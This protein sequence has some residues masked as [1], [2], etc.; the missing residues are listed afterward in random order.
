MRECC[1]VSWW[2]YTAI[3]A[4]QAHQKIVPGCRELTRYAR[5]RKTPRARPQLYPFDVIVRGTASQVN[6]AGTCAR[7]FPSRSRK[8]PSRVPFNSFPFFPFSMWN[9]NV[10]FSV[11]MDVPLLT[12]ASW[13]FAITCATKLPCPSLIQ[14]PMN[15]LSRNV[16]LAKETPVAYIEGATSMTLPPGK[17]LMRLCRTAVVPGVLRVP[18][19][20]P[21]KL[22]EE[23]SSAWLVPG[24]ETRNASTPST[25]KINK[26]RIPCFPILPS[27][28][29][30]PV[31]QQTGAGTIF[32]LNV[33]VRP[34]RGARQMVKIPTTDKSNI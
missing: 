6:P 19:Q 13:I 32:T 33:P 1:V 27:E 2:E 16:P 22:P 23:S 24:P 11:P 21:I 18:L 10:R 30:Y 29:V 3:S 28:A 9:R 26:A 25:H 15:A 14:V 12:G 17:K 8:T 31:L 4:R 5:G 20:E 7:V 34:G